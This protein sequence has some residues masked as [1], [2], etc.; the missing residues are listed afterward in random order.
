[1]GHIFNQSQQNTNG[2]QLPK[3]SISGVGSSQLFQLKAQILAFKYLPR[4][5]PL[6]SK[7]LTAIRGFQAKNLSETSS[8]NQV[9]SNLVSNITNN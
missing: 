5:A 6:P 9:V 4:N 8:K 3:Q 1:M 2:N 7:L